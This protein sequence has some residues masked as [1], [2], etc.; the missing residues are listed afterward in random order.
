MRISVEF[1]LEHLG[2]KFRSNT[3]F[4]TYTR[5]ALPDIVASGNKEVALMI[6]EVL[7]TSHVLLSS[8]QSPFQVLLH[9]KALKKST[10]GKHASSG[11][12]NVERDFLKWLWNVYNLGFKINLGEPFIHNSSVIYDLPWDRQM[13]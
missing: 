10:E 3:E 2:E 7:S 5:K 4:C 6:L 13:E 11:W 12:Q 1:G 8:V 9:K